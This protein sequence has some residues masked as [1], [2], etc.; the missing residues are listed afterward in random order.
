MSLRTVVVIVAV[1][2]GGAA[3]ASAQNVK[4][5]F[6]DGRVD[7]SAQN[8]PLR[9]ILDEWARLGGTKI[10]NGD[11]VPGGQPGTGGQSAFASIL[12]L[13]TS[14]GPRN[15]PA[16]RPNPVFPVAQP[17]FQGQPGFVVGTRPVPP[18]DPDD[19][20]ASDVPPEDDPDENPA[21]RGPRPRVVGPRNQPGIPQPFD[22][23]DANDANDDAPATQAPAP[24]NPFG[25]S[26]GSSRPGE[27]APVPQPQQRPRSQPDPEP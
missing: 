12:I 2:V 18:P 4:L 25:L 1:L 26:T 5:A 15:A 11:R 10:V 22:A 21:A 27:I 20:P 19:D 6:H 13:P 16:P 14:T 23:N 17:R 3:S 7:L 8:A 9:T 24:A